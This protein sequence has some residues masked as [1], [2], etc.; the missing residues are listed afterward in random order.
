MVIM[1]ADRQTASLGL[2]PGMKLADARARVPD[3]LAFDHDPRADAN[4]LARLAE[5]CERYTP[6]VAVD[7]P[8]ALILDI[9]GAAHL[10]DNEQTLAQDAE[11]RLD[12]A[13][14]SAC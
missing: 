8:C 1:A 14:Y 5:A 12:E 2:G 11:D 13:G 10:H 3:L 6:M 4:L 7:P 9:T